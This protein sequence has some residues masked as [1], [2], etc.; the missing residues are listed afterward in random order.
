[1]EKICRICFS[2]QTTCPYTEEDLLISDA[3]GC[4]G[5]MAHVHIGCITKWVIAER[6]VAEDEAIGIPFFRYLFRCNV[7][8]QGHSEKVLL[9]LANR[10]INI[11]RALKRTREKESDKQN[12]FSAQFKRLFSF[13]LVFLCSLL[14]I[15][16]GLVYSYNLMPSRLIAPRI[17]NHADD[18]GA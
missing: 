10:E 17:C 5:S 7:C 3:C 8:K 4:K 11:Y 9:A 1:M 16:T 15:F 6:D 13:I 12:I 2:P 14:F 18:T